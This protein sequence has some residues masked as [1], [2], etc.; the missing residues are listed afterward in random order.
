MSEAKQ[1]S[2][3]I[4]A[5]YENIHPSPVEVQNWCKHPVY[6]SDLWIWLI[7]NK[8]EPAGLGIAEFDPDIKEGSLEWIQVLP[9][10]QGKG[11]IIISKDMVSGSRVP[12]HIGSHYNMWK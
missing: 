5:C 1:I 3:L 4:G 2:D 7:D 9:E 6:D 8:N 12:I 10:Y 11:F